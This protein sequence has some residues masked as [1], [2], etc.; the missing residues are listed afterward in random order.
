M[1]K[2]IFI[3]ISLALIFMNCGS[4]S[5]K[6]NELK[7]QAEEY[8]ESM[9]IEEEIGAQVKA[10]F[11]PLTA[12][13]ENPDN[14]ITDEKVRLGKI[15]YFDNRLSKD[16]TQS[17]N[18]CHNLSTFGVDNEQFSEGDDG[19]SMGDRNSPTVFN[20]AFHTT[21][22]WDSRAKD[23]E[24]QA[25]L[26]ILNPVEMNIPSEDFLIKR[27]AS[28]DLYPPLFAAAFPDESNPLTYDNLKKAIGAFE[29]TLVT[30]SKF[31][32]YLNGN[33]GALSL[34]EKKGLKTF[35]QVGCLTCHTGSQLG[36]NMLQKFGVYDNYWSLTGSDPVDEGR[37]KE[38]GNEIDKYM[39]KVPTLRNVAMTYPYFHDGSVEKLEDAVKIVAKLNLN[40]DLTEEEVK[41]IVIFLN[42]L[43]GDIPEEVK[44]I[45]DELNPAS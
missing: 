4:D 33:K 29:R 25:G 28:T 8:A 32:D 44:K 37:F 21:Q 17:C 5:S 11:Q 3:M 1:K 38:T 9:K 2:S 24:E 14:P 19:T 31:D 45:P 34:E 15:L 41:S 16:Q 40:K 43:T 12:V 27:L 13:A 18:T 6:K 30:P 36:G 20:A 26:P 22:F 42:T 10:M 39:F 35:I 7:K 23:V